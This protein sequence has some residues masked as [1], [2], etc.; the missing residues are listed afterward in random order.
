MGNVFW[1]F[2]AS[3]LPSSLHAE[4]WRGP[5]LCA[6]SL[7][8][9]WALQPLTVV[10]GSWVSRLAL[11]EDQTS[12]KGASGSCQPRVLATDLDSQTLIVI[13]LKLHPGWKP[14]C[15]FS[16]SIRTVCCYR[17]HCSAHQIQIILDDEITPLTEPSLITQCECGISSEWDNQSVIFHVKQIPK[18]PVNRGTSWMLSRLD[19]SIEST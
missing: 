1:D 4:L 9:S 10:G 18:Q 19:T 14:C 12:P 6:L 15:S 13:F 8:T 7:H 2:C 17:T 11:G 16:P 3:L 5:A